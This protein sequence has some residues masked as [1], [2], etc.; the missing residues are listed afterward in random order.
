MFRVIKMKKI[1]LASI[2]LLFGVT[3]L[4]QTSPTYDSTTRVDTNNNTNSTVNSV[5]TTNSNNVNSTTVNSTNNNIS[6]SVNTNNNVNTGHTTSNNV[7]TNVNVSNSTSVQDMTSNS[8]SSSYN[9]NDVTQRI[10]QPPPTAI[11]PSVM[12]GGNNDLCTT[13]VGG[14]IQTQ[15]VG[16]SAGKTTRDLNCERLK[17]SKTLYDMGMKVAAVTLLCQDRRVFDAMMEAGT[18]CPFDGRIGESARQS[19][20][21]NP[22]RIPVLNMEVQRDKT[23]NNNSFF[24]RLFSWLF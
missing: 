8:K 6:T 9:Q 23:T 11:A 1:L 17:L 7:N 2:F 20:Q 15:I 12:S 16:L 14:A 19:W 5:N 10:V 4:S 13:G 21:A 18:P 3:A 24:A 22:D